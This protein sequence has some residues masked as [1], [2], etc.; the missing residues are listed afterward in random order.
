MNFHFKA[1]ILKDRV[2]VRYSRLVIKIT[3][4]MF[5]SQRAKDEHVIFFCCDVPKMP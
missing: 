5:F 3:R 1:D 4:T 2:I